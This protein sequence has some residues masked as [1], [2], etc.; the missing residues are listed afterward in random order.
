MASIEKSSAGMNPYNNVSKL[1][2]DMV[3]NEGKLP[4]DD[5]FYT[6]ARKWAQELDYSDLDKIIVDGMKINSHNCVF[7]PIKLYF[8]GLIDEWNARKMASKE[9]NA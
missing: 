6:A 3:V 9:D 4:S 7:P 8:D 1:V 5:D 2:N